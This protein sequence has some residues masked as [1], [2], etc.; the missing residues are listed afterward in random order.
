MV[1]SWRMEPALW[2]RTI[3]EGRQRGGRWIRVLFSAADVSLRI[4]QVMGRLLEFQ[5][6][7]G[8]ND[9]NNG[10]ADERGKNSYRGP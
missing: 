7:K 6:E 10:K 8:E 1:V 9:G 5:A 2:F 3:R 4:G